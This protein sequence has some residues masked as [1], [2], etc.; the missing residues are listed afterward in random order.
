LFHGV[1]LV[2]ERTRAGKVLSRAPSFIRH[3]YTLFVVMIGWVFFRTEDLPSA[4]N[5]LESMFVFQPDSI[6]L[7]RELL[8]PDVIIAMSAGFIFSTP[9]LRRLLDK[10]ERSGE[11]IKPYLEISY[12]TLLFLAFILCAMS[13]SGGTYNPFIYFRF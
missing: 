1:F 10:M 6:Y 2:V 12:M 4:M 8:S 13:L 5:Y 3:A 9:V 7:L 11:Q